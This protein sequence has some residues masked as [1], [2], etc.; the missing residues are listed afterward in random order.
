[1]IVKREMGNGGWMPYG[2]FIGIARRFGIKS[3]KL[4]EKLKR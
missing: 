1:M 4:E 3:I 2:A